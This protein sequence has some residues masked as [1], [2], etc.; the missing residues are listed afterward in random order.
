MSSAWF[1][2]L[3]NLV[4]LKVIKNTVTKTRRVLIEASICCAVRS[5]GKKVKKVPNSTDATQ[6]EM[7]RLTMMTM[8]IVYSSNKDPSRCL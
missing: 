5:K 2:I 1:C 4:V 8:A 7:S 3:R 6:V